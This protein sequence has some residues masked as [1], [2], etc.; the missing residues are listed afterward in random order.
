MDTRHSHY[1]R[2]PPGHTKGAQNP[3]SDRPG[4]PASEVMPALP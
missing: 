4:P 2:A 1:V 3:L